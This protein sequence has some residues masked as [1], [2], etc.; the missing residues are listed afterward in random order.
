M[1]LFYSV[2]S[3]IYYRVSEETLK[4]NWGNKHGPAKASVTEAVLEHR[5]STNSSLE[6]AC[7]AL[8][9]VNSNV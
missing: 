4:V 8:K 5:K 7:D 1:A 9:I 6:F 3:S 2:G